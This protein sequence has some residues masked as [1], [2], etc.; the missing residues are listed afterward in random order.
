LEEFLDELF[1][2]LSFKPIFYIL[3]KAHEILALEKPSNFSQAE[4]Y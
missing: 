1:I 3:W 2:Q 4:V